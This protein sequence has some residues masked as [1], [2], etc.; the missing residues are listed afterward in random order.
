MKCLKK[1]YEWT[2]GIRFLHWITFIAIAV[3]TFTGFYIASPFWFVHTPGTKE[4]YKIF[5]MANVRLIHFI[6]AYVFIFA[7]ILRLYYA[8]FSRHDADWKYFLFGWLDVK[9]WFLTLKNYLTFKPY[10]VEGLKSDK[11]NPVQSLAYFAFILFSI[12]QIITGII[13]YTMNDNSIRGV[14]FVQKLLFPVVQLF[15]GYPN[16]RIAHHLIT[17]F[18]IVFVIAHVYMVIAHDIGEKNGSLS[19]MFTGYKCEEK[20]E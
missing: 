13:L 8:F 11:Y 19:S 20:N 15:G 18:F 2:I 12:L 14:A 10:G 7:I 4:A 6:A 9:G 3:L 5:S 16:V 1:K 17:W